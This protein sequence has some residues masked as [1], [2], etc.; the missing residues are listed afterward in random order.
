MAGEPDSLSFDRTVEIDTAAPV[1]QDV[2][3][4]QPNGTYTTGAVIGVAVHFS[5]P[6]MIVHADYPS[7]CDIGVCVGLPVLELDVSGENGDTS[8]TYAS[9]SG[10]T[11]LIFEYEASQTAWSRMCASDNDVW[12]GRLYAG[13]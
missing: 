13:C 8:A 10:T 12:G 7:N 1:V 11:D 3:S 4:T 9:G 5:S 2:T 6:V